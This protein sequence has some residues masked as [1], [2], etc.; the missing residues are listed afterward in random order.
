MLMLVSAWMRLDTS[1]RRVCGDSRTEA[2]AAEDHG[3]G[4]CT[5][6]HWWVIDGWT[7]L[8]RVIEKLMLCLVLVLYLLDSALMMA[9]VA[10]NVRAVE[11]L[12]EMGASSSIVNSSGMTALMCAARVGYDPRSGAANIEDRM[13]QSARI[14]DILLANGADANVVEKVEGN[15]A[16]HLAVQSANSSAVESLLANARYLDIAVQNEAKDTALDLC[17]RMSGLASVQM[18]DLLSEK[19]TQYEKAA[20]ERSAKMEQELLCLALADAAGESTAMVQ[21]RTKKN[22]TKAK[23]LTSILSSVSATAQELEDWTPRVMPESPLLETA[24]KE[25]ALQL[26]SARVDE[27][28]GDDDGTWQCVATKKSRELACTCVGFLSVYLKF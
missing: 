14:V 13:E 22:K 10:K 21:S 23:S 7:T 8:R 19:W 3:P 25:T 20:A 6:R 27:S 16:L 9:C 12:L 17:K 28:F 1:D 15:T 11:L 26:H 5:W 18:E 24:S 2:E 4:Q